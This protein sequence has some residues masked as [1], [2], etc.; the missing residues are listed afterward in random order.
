[1][2][3]P[4]LQQLETLRYSE[5]RRLAKTAGLKSNLKTDKLLS[6]LKHHFYGPMQE[7]RSM[8]SKRSSS[9]DREALAK[10]SVNLSMVSQRHRRQED[11]DEQSNQTE[12]TTM[13]ENSGFPPVT[14]IMTESDKSLS[15]TAMKMS[16][17]ECQA[18]NEIPE[19]LPANSD[20]QCQQRK[21]NPRQKGI[22]SRTPEISLSGR[23]LHCTGSLPKSDRKRV[24]S[25]PNFKK[26]HETQFNKMQSIVDYIEKK[27]KRVNKFSNSVNEVKRCSISSKKRLSATDTPVL[28]RRSPRN[29]L[30]TA[31]KS[32][33]NQKSSFSK[34]SLSTTKLNVR[35]SE[36]TNDNEHKR[37]LTKTPSRKSPFPHVC[38]PASQKINKTV[39]GK[40]SKGSAVLCQLQKTP[41]N[42]A[43]TPFK[44]IAQNP[45]SMSKK[46]PVF[47]LQASLSKTLNYQPHKGKLKPW[48]KS[49]DNLQNVCSHK[50]AYKQPHLQTREE[51]RERQVQ[52]RKKRKDHV[53]GTRRGLAV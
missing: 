23:K 34:T 33:L 15:G 35:F 41:T 12:E 29:S 5:L 52:E 16:R 9:A 53:L 1:M 39:I 10:V 25:T 50:K 45:G 46:K 48:G 26:L 18:D 24:I 17:D 49:K 14:E 22:E 7:N 4:P 3:P 38:T 36:S 28:L 47:D 44:F 11:C 40:D 20:I 51:R 6:T 43:V 13:E 30:D 27:K 42:S 8:V 21:R 2:E 32:I 37:S 19:T 31:N